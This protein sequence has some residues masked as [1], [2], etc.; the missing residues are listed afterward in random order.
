[1]W[2]G[3]DIAVTLIV[4]GP[5]NIVKSPWKV[6]FVASVLAMIGMKQMMMVVMADP[7]FDTLYDYCVCGRDTAITKPITAIPTQP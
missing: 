5:I 6:E 4:L 1:M 3:G 2:L 7:E